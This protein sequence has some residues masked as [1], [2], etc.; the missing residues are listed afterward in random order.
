[1]KIYTNSQE[2]LTQASEPTKLA[3]PIHI[4][5]EYVEEAAMLMAL[6]GSLTGYDS[7]NLINMFNTQ[8]NEAD[9][10]AFSWKFTGEL[11]DILHENI[12]ESFNKESLLKVKFVID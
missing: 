10:K 4:E 1:M 5:L 11:F 7:N 2:E 9:A 8:L 12:P 6:V 3:T